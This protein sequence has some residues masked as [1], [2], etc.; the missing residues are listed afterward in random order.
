M[1]LR[2]CTCEPHYNNLKPDDV[3]FK[4]VARAI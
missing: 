2:R 1:R 3:D 4:L